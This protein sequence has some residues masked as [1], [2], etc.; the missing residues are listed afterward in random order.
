MTDDQ[1]MPPAQQTDEN[2]A[3]EANGPQ[4]AHAPTIRP[5]MQVPP[6]HKHYKISC[7]KKRDGWDRAKLVAEF[8]GIVFLIIYTLYT[9]GI[10]CANRRAAEAAHDTLGE[11]QKQ[12]TLMRQQLVGT[13]AASL[14]YLTPAWHGLTEQEEGKVSETL[15]NRGLVSARDAQLDVTVTRERL[16]DFKP[17]GLPITF[18][19]GPEIVKAGDRM[20]L[21]WHMPWKLKVI[22]SP[23]GPSFPLN[24]WPKDWPGTETTEI[25]GVFK[26]NDGFDDVV[27]KR[28]C[29][30][31]L[32][33]FSY[34]GPTYSQ[35]IG[36]MPTC[37]DT[38]STIQWALAKRNELD[39]QR[40]QR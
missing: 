4:S 22:V 39:A 2:A 26:Y 27:T 14:D 34:A 1:P 12:T 40:K 30:R 5:E 25:N 8:V 11:I 10:Y 31:W 6:A 13:Q 16:S 9:A 29:F 20:V 32:P 36:G 15:I 3:D 24:D 19:R 7:E 23:Q 18:H 17:L 37:E 33:M 38:L 35:G 21:E 28:F